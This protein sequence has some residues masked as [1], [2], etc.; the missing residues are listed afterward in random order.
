MILDE[1]I[2]RFPSGWMDYRERRKKGD[3]AEGFPIIVHSA[4]DEWACQFRRP[5][6]A[7]FL[8]D[9]APFLGICFEALCRSSCSLFKSAANPIQLVSANQTNRHQSLCHFEVSGM[10]DPFLSRHR[11]PTITI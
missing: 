9:A 2:P 8:R 3:K 4:S 1:W 6:E 11:W 7:G 5:V 10:R